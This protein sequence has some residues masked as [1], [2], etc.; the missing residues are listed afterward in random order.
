MMIERGGD[1]YTIFFFSACFND[2]LIPYHEMMHTL[3]FIHEQTRP[4]RDR[5]INLNPKNIKKG[6]AADFAKIPHG[7]NA[8]F[9]KGTEVNAMNT[10]YDM[11]SLMHYGPYQAA[12]SDKEPV[13]TFLFNEHKEDEN[14]EVWPGS[15]IEDPLSL[16]DQVKKH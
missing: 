12:K 11:G 7:D 3:G 14:D 6:Y 1:I 5:F 4:D 10:P 9:P 15:S 2:P 13:F 16:I 8:Y